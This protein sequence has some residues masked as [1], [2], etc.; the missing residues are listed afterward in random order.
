MPFDQDTDGRYGCQVDGRRL[1][2]VRIVEVRIPLAARGVLI[3]PRHQTMRLAKVKR[4][5]ASIA[6]VCACLAAPLPAV[7]ELEWHAGASVGQAST[8]IDDPTQEDLDEVAALFDSELGGATISNLDVSSDDSD[9]AWKIFFGARANEYFGVEAFYVD[10]GKFTQDFSADISFG[11]NGESVSGTL[12]A[13]AAYEG[14][15][16]GL[17]VLAGVPLS[18]RFNVFAKLGFSQWNVDLAAEATFDGTVGGEPLVVSER[19][20][21]DDDGTDLMYGVGASV[22]FTDALGARVEWERFEI[23]AF[24]DSVDVDLISAGVEFVF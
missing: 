12:G 22:R 16:Y 21:D 7:A 1:V 5:V 15:A 24:D 11:A 17:A 9:T 19:E 20:S 6:A 3:L 8:D 14:D 10:F 23:D 18:D 13:D 4:Y 2:E